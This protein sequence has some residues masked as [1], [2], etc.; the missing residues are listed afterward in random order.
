MLPEANTRV[1]ARIRAYGLGVATTGERW[2]FWLETTLEDKTWRA[3][4][5]V[6]ASGL[7]PN[8]RPVIDAPRVSGWLKG[9]RPSYDLAA[10]AGECLGVGADEA[11]AAA[12]YGQAEP[13]PRREFTDADD[14]GDPEQPVGLGLDAAAVG[15]TAEEIEPILAIVRAIKH[16][17]GLDSP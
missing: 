1:G 14:P 13:F 5:L 12:G 7:K 2:A 10:L 4:D 8:G 9:E 6:R 16:A 11:L 17:K 3:A 15:L